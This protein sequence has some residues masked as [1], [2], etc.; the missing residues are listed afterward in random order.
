MNKIMKEKAEQLFTSAL[1]IESSEER[2]I[3]LERACQGDS[4]L[5]ELV[6][7]MISLRVQWE[8]FFPEG[9][10]VFTLTKDMFNDSQRME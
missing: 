1:R 6:E 3:F 7:K 8:K 2:K 4:E 10:V 5:R 9:G